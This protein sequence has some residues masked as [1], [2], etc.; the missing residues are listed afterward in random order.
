MG[1]W[2]SP[3]PTKFQRWVARHV[4]ALQIVLACLALVSAGLSLIALRSG[5]WPRSAVGPMLLVVVFIGW[6]RTPPQIAR[7]VAEYD[8]RG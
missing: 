4:V 7:F 2:D 1:R 6:T 8:R 3:P 5:G